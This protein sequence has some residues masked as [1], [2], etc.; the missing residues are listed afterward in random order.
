MYV[1]F[2]YTRKSKV[3]STLSRPLDWCEKESDVYSMVLKRLSQTPDEEDYVEC[4]GD[5]THFPLKTSSDAEPGHYSGFVVAH[6][7]GFNTN[8]GSEYVNR[9]VKTK[10]FVQRFD[11]FDIKEWRR[12]SKENEREFCKLTGV[13]S[14]WY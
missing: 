12:A 14:R 4:A 2:R 11:R 7:P 5:P 1:L 8:V 9:S 3:E 13:V 10:H 6:L